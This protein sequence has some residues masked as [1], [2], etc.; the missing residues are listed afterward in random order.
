M[1][2][3]SDY[4]LHARECRALA[5]KMDLGEPRDQLLAMARHWDQLAEERAEL[6]RRH[7]ELAIDGE[8]EEED[9]AA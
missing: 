9:G 3:A 6:V 4:R 1:K 8:L 2:K 7:P 5:A